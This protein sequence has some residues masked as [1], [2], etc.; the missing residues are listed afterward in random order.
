MSNEAE[1]TGVEK[2]LGSKRCCKKS[3]QTGNAE[4]VLTW[5]KKIPSYLI[6]SEVS[7]DK[8]KYAAPPVTP[9]AILDTATEALYQLGLG[10]YFI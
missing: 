3:E 8:T 9:A 7:K 4:V 6:S 10:M 2:H 5:K 1:H